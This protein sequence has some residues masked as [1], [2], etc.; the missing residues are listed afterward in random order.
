MWTADK[1]GV[2]YP[3]YW[4]TGAMPSP[5]REKGSRTQ[6][7]T[8]HKKVATVGIGYITGHLYATTG[9]D[10]EDGIIPHLYTTRYLYII[11]P[12]I[13]RHGRRRR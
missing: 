10:D 5:I 2:I 9:I 13:Y 12:H 1:D 11:E 7:T 3:P 8:P 6:S 4:N